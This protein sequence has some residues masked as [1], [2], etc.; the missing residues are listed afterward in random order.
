[1]PSQ[2]TEGKQIREGVEKWL[3]ITRENLKHPHPKV[4]S[5]GLQSAEKALALDPQNLE[6]RLLMARIYHKLGNQRNVEKWCDNALALAPKSPEVLVRTTMLQIPMLVGDVSDVERARQRY[7]HYLE[8]LIVSTDL[9]DPQIVAETATALAK[10]YPFYLSYLGD[11]IRADQET[12]GRFV[13]A[14]MRRHH[15]LTVKPVSTQPYDGKRPIHIGIPFGNF[16]KQSN[17]FVNIKGYLARLDRE[18]FHIIGYNL[19]QRDDEETALAREWCAEFVEKKSEWNAPDWI[20]RIQADQHDILLYPEIK[21]HGLALRLAALRLARVQIATWGQPYTTGLP[22]IDYFLSSEAMEPPDAQAHY[23]EKLVRLARLS[24]HYIPNETPT[25]VLPRGHFGLRENAIVYG[26]MQS[27]WKYQPQHDFLFAK[28]ARLVP[29]SQFVFLEHRRS[30]ALTYLVRDRMQ[31]AFSAEGINVDDHLIMLPYLTHIEYHSVLR[32]CDVYLDSVE[33]GGMAT[34]F[35]VLAYAPPI[36][37]LKGSYFRGRVGYG[38]LQ[39]MG[40]TDIIAD[41]LDEY[42]ELAVEL[43]RNP[44]RRQTIRQQMATNRHKAYRDDD[45]IASLDQFFLQAVRSARNKYLENV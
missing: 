42:I 30:A 37:T 9:D 44:E 14:V 5:L 18:R 29:D 17:W 24:V 16:G 12:Y 25:E 21:M 26:C 36:V 7:R 28:I 8:T 43:G 3:N 45:C 33:W 39:E 23:S 4:T 27:I 1:M 19:S 38:I 34:F 31:A 20:K 40:V 2:K 35:E 32:H 22:T 10:S 11:N 13:S 41:T 15:Q 6:G